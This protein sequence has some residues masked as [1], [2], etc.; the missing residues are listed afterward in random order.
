MRLGPISIWRITDSEFER[1]IFV[2]PGFRI[3]HQRTWRIWPP[4]WRAATL[5]WPGR[6]ARLRRAVGKR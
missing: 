5:Y 6:L 1:G 2:D 3:L 4:S